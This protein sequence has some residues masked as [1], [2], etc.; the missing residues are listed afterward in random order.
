VDSPASFATNDAKPAA[1]GLRFRHACRADLRAL[2]GLLDGDAINVAREGHTSVVTDAVAQ[3]FAAIEAST[4]NQLIV[5]EQAGDVVGMLQLTLIPGLARGGRWRALVESV[6]VRADRRGHG[7]GAALMQYAMALARD[8]GA[9][10]MQLTS[11]KRRVDAHRFY[12]QLGFVDSHVG[13]KRE[14]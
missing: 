9:G 2:L 6:H 4:S 11:D 5:A 10:I 14:L 3:A 8:A 13:M 1:D 12:A 7:I